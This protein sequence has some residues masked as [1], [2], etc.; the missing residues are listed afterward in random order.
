VVVSRLTY[1]P[2]SSVQT[3]MASTNLAAILSVVS[4]VVSLRKMRAGRMVQ[5]QE[6][7]VEPTSPS[8]SSMS[9]TRMP[10]VRHTRIT[11]TVIR[12]NLAGEM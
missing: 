12:L 4:L 10:T 2:S 9:G 1:V 7:M 6:P 3:P 11:H 5:T 8:T